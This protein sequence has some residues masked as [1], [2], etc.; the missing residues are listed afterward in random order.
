MNFCIVIPNYNHTYLLDEY[1]EKLAAFNLPVIM[2]NDG[3]DPDAKTLFLTLA[4]KFSF[5]TLVEHKLNQGKGAAVQTA[6]K[7]A[8]KQGY[9]HALQIDADGQH[10]L[11]DIS[12]MMAEST[13]YPKALISGKPIYDDS[14]PK[15]RYYARNITHFWVWVETLSFKIKDTMCGYRVYPLVSTIELLN[16]HALGKRM[17]FDIEIMV[18]MYWRNIELRFL[19][20]AVNYPEHGVS[21]FRAFEDNVLI[22]WMHTRLCLG[23]IIRLPILLFRKL[24]PS[25]GY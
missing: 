23:M 20:T 10:D 12:K 5:L 1:M 17:D 21:H 22:S 4:A 13:T 19:P 25:A 24:K 3:S 8:F 6:F 2:V 9:S 7:A 18:R 11:N 16:S 15:L 14:I